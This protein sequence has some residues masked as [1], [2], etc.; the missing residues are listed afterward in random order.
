MKLN[1]F[2]RVL[3]TT[4][5]LVFSMLFLNLLSQAQKLN[6][7]NLVNAVYTSENGQ[8]SLDTVLFVRECNSSFFVTDD[9]KYQS[10]KL[11]SFF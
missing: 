5:L 3:K 6:I 7:P 10:I 4:W 9:T 2:M 11:L 8:N 1:S